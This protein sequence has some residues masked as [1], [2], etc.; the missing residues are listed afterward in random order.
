M[1]GEPTL[2]PRLGDMRRK[3]LQAALARAAS[4]FMGTPEGGYFQAPV[5]PGMTP[6]GGFFR[7][8]SQPTAVGTPEGGF[9]Q[10]PMQPTAVGTP[11]GGFFQPPAAP[12][13]TNAFGPQRRRD[14]RTVPAMQTSDAASPNYGAVGRGAVS[15]FGIRP[16]GRG[17]RPSAILNFLSLRSPAGFAGGRAAL[18]SASGGLGRLVSDVQ[19]P[20]PLP[21]AQVG[22]ISAGGAPPTSAQG[23]ANALNSENPN[24]STPASV[25]PSGSV[26]EGSL[27]GWTSAPAAGGSGLI[28]L[29]G[30]IFLDPDT[31]QLHGSG[32]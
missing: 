16:V 11:E 4:S 10:P 23:F 12:S 21:A 19:M 13:P 32:M 5:V 22:G 2:D 27:P 9:F 26:F 6:E 3:A 25:L 28:P 14:R 18:Q 24:A 30:G 7:P 17:T 1:I 15:G 31:G 29:G 20:Q 8:P